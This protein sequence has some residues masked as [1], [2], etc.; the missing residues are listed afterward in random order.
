[1]NL[2]VLAEGAGGALAALGAYRF[3]NRYGGSS[4]LEQLERA[5]RILSARVTELE[6]TNASQAGQ[7]AKLEASRDVSLAI[8]PVLEALRT[9]EVEAA[10]RSKATLD[11]LD[12]IASRLGSEREAA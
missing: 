4:A 1:V 2:A 9:H 10:K 3:T 11:V 5:N 12:L 7:I 8:V 6:A